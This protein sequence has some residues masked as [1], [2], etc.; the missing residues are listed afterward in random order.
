MTTGITPAGQ[1][2]ACSMVRAVFAA[3]FARSGAS[4]LRSNSSKPRIAPGPSKPIW[5]SLPSEATAIMLRRVRTRRSWTNSPS[6]L[7]I[8]T[9]CPSWTAPARFPN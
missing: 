1:F 8:Q 6:L 2:G 3:I 9:R 7:A 5:F 4:I